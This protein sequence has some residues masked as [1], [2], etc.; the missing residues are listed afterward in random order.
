VIAVNR[1]EELLVRAFISPARRT[2]WLQ[3]LASVKRRGPFLDRL[4]H[5]QDIDERFAT[6][7]PSNADVITLLKSHG[8]PETCYVVSCT[9]D[10]DGRE[11]P[12]TKAVEDAEFHGWGTIISCIP[13]RLAYYYDECGERRMLLERKAEPAIVVPAG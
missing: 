13:G 12:L 1:N 3:S 8:A 2:R 6:P 9:A 4:N 11:L 7:L 10:I 5:C